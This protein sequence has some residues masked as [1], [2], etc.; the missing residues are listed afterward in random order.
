[1]ILL[2]EVLAEEQGLQEIDALRCRGPGHVGG[3]LHHTLH[4]EILDRPLSG[5]SAINLG[6]LKVSPRKREQRGRIGAAFRRKRN[7]ASEDTAEDGRKS[8]GLGLS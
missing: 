7:K 8:E 1:M 3:A 5:R 4:P 6:F 2:K